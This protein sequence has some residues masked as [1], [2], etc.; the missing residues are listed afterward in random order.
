[1]NATR[2]KFG[3]DYVLVGLKAEPSIVIKIDGSGWTKEMAV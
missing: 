2:Q 3:F 1:M